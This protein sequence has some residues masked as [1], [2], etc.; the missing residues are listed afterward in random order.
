MICANSALGPFGAW[1][2]GLG[3]KG[4]TPPPPPPPLQ[5]PLMTFIIKQKNKRLGVDWDQIHHRQFLT[6][7]GLFTKLGNICGILSLI[8]CNLKLLFIELFSTRSFYLRCEQ[9]AS[10]NHRHT[11]PW[12]VSKII[13]K[14]Q[15]LHV[16]GH[17]VLVTSTTSHFEIQQHIRN[18]LDDKYMP[19]Y[20]WLCR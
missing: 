13:L 19:G 12:R 2:L 17:H 3:P 8:P 7:M 4:S 20:Y 11:A 9:E 18:S 15:R 16:T 14:N 5:P 1:G 10:E 6:K